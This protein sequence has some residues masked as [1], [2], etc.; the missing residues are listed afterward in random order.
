MSREREDLSSTFFTLL[1]E[2]TLC[3]VNK[4]ENGKGIGICV[5]TSIGLQGWTEILE[6]NEMRIKHE[7]I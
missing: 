3:K 2:L 4:C 7:Q 5:K 6:E 1:A